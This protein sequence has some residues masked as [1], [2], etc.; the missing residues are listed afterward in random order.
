ML[1]KLKEKKAYTLIEIVAVIVILGLLLLI[2]VPAVNKQLTNFRINYYKKLEQSIASAA[3]DFISDNSRKKPTKVFHSRVIKVSELEKDG[4]IDEAKDYIG[5]S[6][7]NSDNSYSYVLV[8]KTGVKEYDYTTCLKCS[9]DEYATD[10]TGTKNNYCDIA[11][12]TNEYIEYSMDEKYQKPL[13]IYYGTDQGSIIEQSKI[14]YDIIKENNNGSILAT[15]VMDRADDTIVPSNVEE[16]FNKELNTTINLKYILSDEE[17]LTRNG[18]IYK[19]N[20]PTVEMYY[21]NDNVYNGKTKNENY[22]NGEWA[23]KLVVKF[24]FSD[25][26]TKKQY[27]KTI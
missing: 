3:K 18:I 7:D 5:K 20:K 19:H 24:S 9:Q 25:E 10:T 4:Y 26:E 14:Y 1:K 6:C 17:V 23:N 15:K 12:M 22:S 21:G 16:L 8:V 27:T 13:Y 11:W 2:A